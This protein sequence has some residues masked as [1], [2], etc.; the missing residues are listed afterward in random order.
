MTDL[1]DLSQQLG[2]LSPDQI[3]LLQARLRRLRRREGQE[4]PEGIAR[5]ENPAGPFPLSFQQEQLWFLEQLAQGS[6]AFNQPL[7][8][9][10]QGTLDVDALGRALS[11]IIARH[12]ILRTVFRAEEGRP[13]QVVAPEAPCDLPLTDLRALPETERGATLRTLMREHARRPMD[14]ARGPLM[15]AALF[16]LGPA[17]QVLGV[18]LHHIASDGWS[19]GLLVEELVALYRASRE[20]LPSS[21]P[22]LAVQY[23][24]YAVWQR[25]QLAGKV[26]EEGVAWWRR[27][28]AGAP[29]SR[30][31]PPTGCG[32]RPRQTVAP[33]V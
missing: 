17:D 31:S 23:G 3:A 32:R 20:S 29:P 16:R 4:G 13:T 2:Q 19:F 18:V 1:S 26:L 28:L 6:T 5:Q 12:S 15:R 21:L 10:L 14:L 30:S 27:Q 8:L 25:R 22:K 9:R 24:D 33:C 11:A 7:A